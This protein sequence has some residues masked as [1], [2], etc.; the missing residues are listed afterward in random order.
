M[1]CQLFDTDKTSCSLLCYFV[2]SLICSVTYF[3]CN[4]RNGM[5]SLH[6]CSLISANL[7][8]GYFLC[9]AFVFVMKSFYEQIKWWWWWWCQVI[10]VN[11]LFVQT[12][13]SKQVTTDVCS[14]ID[15]IHTIIVW[16][17]RF[18]LLFYYTQRQVNCGQKAWCIELVYGTGTSVSGWM[19]R[20]QVKLWNPLRMCAIPS[21]LKVCSW[22]GAMQ[23]HV[24]LYVYLTGGTL[25]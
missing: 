5:K 7:F 1:E 22:Q 9:K 17:E 20:L 3:K 6:Y 2:F 21:P 10:V 24:Y 18:V 23:I 19:R 14:C 25:G 8:I 4:C 15:T 13:H 16:K 12:S 11:L